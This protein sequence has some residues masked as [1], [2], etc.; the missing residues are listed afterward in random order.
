ML[1]VDRARRLGEGG[2]DALVPVAM[3]DRLAALHRYLAELACLL[4]GLRE[5]HHFD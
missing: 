5:R 1:G 4:A 2:R 3:G